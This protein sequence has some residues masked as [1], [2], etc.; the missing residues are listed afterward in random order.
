MN[1]LD[2]NTTSTKVSSLQDVN[3]NR[4]LSKNKGADVTVGRWLSSQDPMLRAVG[5]RASGGV[6]DDGSMVAVGYCPR[7][8]DK[9]FFPGLEQG[10][11]KATKSKLLASAYSMASLSHW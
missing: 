7:V 2:R 4:N 3:D 11:I 9:S 10:K 5:V 6:K 8:V 1:V